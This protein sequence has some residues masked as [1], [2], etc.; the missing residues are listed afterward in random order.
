MRKSRYPAVSLVV[1]T[2][3]WPKMLDQVLGSI[4]QQTMIIEEVLVCDDGSDY[5]TQAVIDV[6]REK[7]SIVHLWQSDRGFRAASARNLA[8]LKAKNPYLIFVDGDCL[9]PPTFVEN[10]LK[11]ADENKIVSG[12]RHL[13]AVPL[14]HLDNWLQIR[15][16]KLWRIPLGALR[17]MCAYKWSIVRTCNLSLFR[18][19]ALDVMGFDES[20]VGWGLEDSDFVVRLIRSGLKVRSARFA[21]TV[22]HTQHALESRENLS[23]NIE[24]FNRVLG[25]DARIFP[26]K[27]RLGQ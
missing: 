9:L 18:R 19:R 8:I 12:G 26:D 3:N 4:L 20:Y 27:T 24:R 21:A 16:W 5:R 22:V 2:Y 23:G 6:W 1:T 25:D 10:H 7:L 17:D 13:C 15:H 11:L 14:D